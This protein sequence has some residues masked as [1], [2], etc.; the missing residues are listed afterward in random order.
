M[1]K[2]NGC[3]PGDGEKEMWMA[4]IKIFFTL[5][6]IEPARCPLVEIPS[7][8]KIVSCTLRRK[9]PFQGSNAREL[10]GRIAHLCI[11]H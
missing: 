5:V 8:S 3:Y 9:F 1:L 4:E 10:Q 6:G 11:H 2:T 7:W